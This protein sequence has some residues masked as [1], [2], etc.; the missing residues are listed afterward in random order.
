MVLL[1]RLRQNTNTKYGEAQLKLQCFRSMRTIKISGY[2]IY[3]FPNP[4]ENMACIARP[5]LPF[6][7]DIEITPNSL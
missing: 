7:T 3:K 5:I 4:L 2:Y 1:I 6:N